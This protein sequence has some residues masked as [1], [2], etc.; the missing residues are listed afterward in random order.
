MAYS[1][2]Y[3]TNIKK[4]RAK[5]PAHVLEKEKNELIAKTRTKQKNLIS[6]ESDSLEMISNYMD[7]TYSKGFTHRF[8]GYIKTMNGEKL[9]AFRRLDRGNFNTT[10]KI[11]AV[12]SNFE[13]Y[14]CTL[15]VS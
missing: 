11:I 5:Q 2:R 6:W 9:I 7:H 3:K 8:N 14:F 10:S 15:P 1:G 12:G 4:S 13:V